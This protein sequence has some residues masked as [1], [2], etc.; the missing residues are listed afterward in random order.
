MAFATGGVDALECVMRKIGVDDAEFTAPTGNGRIHLYTASLDGGAHVGQT[1]TLQT[2]LFASQA[3]IDAYDMVLFPCVGAEHDQTAADQNKLIAYANAGGRV[4][5]THYSYV[6]LFNDAPFSGTA[7]WDVG[8]AQPTPDPGTGYIDMTFPKGQEL[9]QW[10][11]VVLPQPPPPLG[12]IQIAVLRHDFDQVI[13]P[14]QPW[15]YAEAPNGPTMHYTF[16]TP[17]NAT[18]DN[19]CGRV[20]F[21]DFHVEDAVTDGT[22]GNVHCYNATGTQIT[23]NCGADGAACGTGGTCHRGCSVGGFCPTGSASGATC[24]KSFPT[25][26][27]AGAMTPQ[28]K[29]LEFMLFDLGSCVT[30]D[31]PTCT[32]SSCMD[33]GIGC[34]PAGDGCGNLQ[35]CGNCPAGQTC[36]GGG[37][38]GQCGTPQCTPLTCLDLGIGCG[39]AGDGCG[40]QLDCG[41]CSPPATCGGGGTPG[42]CG[43]GTCTPET[44]TQLGMHCG[45]AG[46]GCGNTIQCGTCPAGQT[47]GG[48]GMPGVCG[49]N[50][51]KLTCAGLGYDCGLAGDG[52]GGQL[53][54]GTCS[55][56]Q[57]CGGG[58]MPNVCGG[59]GPH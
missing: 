47:C 22:C 7:V 21:D 31:Q 43:T 45:P 16:N 38:P 59:A 18:P 46:D 50:C 52:C 30:P 49:S 56:P 40:G 58:G 53:S 33:L 1:P 5:A 55:P 8:Q 13:A 2:T 4:F 32:P 17:I 44:C 20:L 28:E 34:G 14:S 12:Q 54:C 37:N 26:C 15:M 36:G 39:P 11:Q 25:E 48:G 35:Q 27:A 51:T 41:S 23:G 42:Q 29:L 19:Q 3:A 24:G 10:L 9:A 57:T 6:W